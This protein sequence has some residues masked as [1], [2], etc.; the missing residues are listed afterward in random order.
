MSNLLNCFFSTFISRVYSFVYLN[1]LS[2]FKR[3]VQFHFE[4]TILSFF[5]QTIPK[6]RDNDFCESIDHTLY[7]KEWIYKGLFWFPVCMWVLS[8]NYSGLSE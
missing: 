3:H 8:K 7:L 6:D 5:Y 1:E 2:I 4:S